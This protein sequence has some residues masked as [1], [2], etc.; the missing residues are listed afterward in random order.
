MLLVDLESNCITVPDVK[1]FISERPNVVITAVIE[2]DI[3]YGFIVHDDNRIYY[4]WVSPDA[5]RTGVASYLISAV[6]NIRKRPLR[7][8]V[9]RDCLSVVKLL[10]L[11]NFTPIGMS[12]RYTLFESDHTEL[13]DTDCQF[14][15]FNTCANLLLSHDCLYK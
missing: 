5:R 3:P 11:N 12:G 13:T 7:A 2:Y 6:K 10:A 4:V 14:N 15:L 9:H 8:A 1:K